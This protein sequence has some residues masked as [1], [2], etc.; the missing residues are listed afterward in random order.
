MGAHCIWGKSLQ[1]RV[2]V[3]GGK[4]AVCVCARVGVPVYVLRRAATAAT[5]VTA[6]S[7]VVGVM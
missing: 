3:G 4:Q 7:G 2:V 5:T 1:Q 6:A